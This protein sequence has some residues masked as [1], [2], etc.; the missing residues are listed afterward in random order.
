[1]VEADEEKDLMFLEAEGDTFLVKEGSFAIFTPE[2]AHRPGMCAD[3][4]QPI[5]KAVV[6]VLW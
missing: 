4:P 1:M 3:Q 2:D 5:R 6:K